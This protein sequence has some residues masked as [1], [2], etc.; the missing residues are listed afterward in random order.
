MNKKQDNHIRILYRKKAW[1]FIRVVCI[2]V[3]DSWWPPKKAWS[4]IKLDRYC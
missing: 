2:S 4:F 3:L 1:S